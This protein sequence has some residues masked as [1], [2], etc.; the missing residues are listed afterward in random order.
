MPGRAP[1]N[2]LVYVVIAV[3]GGSAAERSGVLPGDV[4]PAALVETLGS[5]GSIDIIRG[6]APLRITIA[7]VPREK[8]AAA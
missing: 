8:S 4:V 5:A 6:G 3:E 7:R 2:A 1:N